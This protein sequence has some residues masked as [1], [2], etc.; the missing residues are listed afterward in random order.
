M[1]VIDGS[2]WFLDVLMVPGC[3][4]LFFEVFHGS[5]YLLVILCGYW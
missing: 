3:S 4:L 5:W 2:W 1:I